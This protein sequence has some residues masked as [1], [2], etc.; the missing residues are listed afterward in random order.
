MPVRAETFLPGIHW[1][2]PPEI[3]VN[4]GCRAH[5]ESAAS[6]GRIARATRQRP[7]VGQA[8]G[9]FTMKKHQTLADVLRDRIRKSGLSAKALS[10]E[11]GVKQPT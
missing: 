6:V 4:G 2:I 11:T 8:A 7:A 3:Q 10:I 5:S 9:E 1:A